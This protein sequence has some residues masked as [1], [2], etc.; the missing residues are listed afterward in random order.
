MNLVSHSVRRMDG[1]VGERMGGFTQV[2][3]GISCPAT[4]HFDEVSLK[5]L[6]AA[7]KGGQCEPKS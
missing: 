2:L 1:R 3:D 4:D 7:A 5:G 6:C